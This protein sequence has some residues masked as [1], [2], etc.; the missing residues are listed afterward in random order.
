MAEKL[1]VVEVEKEQPGLAERFGEQPMPEGAPAQESAPLSVID[2]VLMAEAPLEVRDTT[3]MLVAATAEANAEQEALDN[4]NANLV[5]ART[6]PPSCEECHKVLADYDI[7]EYRAEA[8]GADDNNGYPRVCRGC[9]EKRTT[10]VPVEVL[11]P[12]EMLSPRRN[13]LNEILEEMRADLLAQAR[14]GVADMVAKAFL[15]EGALAPETAK[16]MTSAVGAQLANRLTARKAGYD[17][18]LGAIAEHVQ[19]NDNDVAQEIADN[20]SVDA[21]DVAEVL[22]E[23][24]DT[25][26]VAEMVAKEIVIEARDVA[27]HVKVDT[28]EVVKG[29]AESIDV[30][31]VAKVFAENMDMDEL[32]EA[33]AEEVGTDDCAEGVATAA[34]E[35]L[36]MDEVAREVARRIQP[37]LLNAVKP[38]LERI[39]H[40][41][42]GLGKKEA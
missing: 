20:M 27:E 37:R 40:E 21:S 15:V 22:A 42:C 29:L 13:L 5:T 10:V 16:E 14:A 3:E 1:N 6:L 39:V 31:D 23:G 36:D 35:A 25:D 28:D 41:A 24:I 17:A 9:A 4:E 34:A 8:N 19:I 11:P 32:V 18:L 38:L 12:I 30:D 26:E 33:V 7:R 2:Q